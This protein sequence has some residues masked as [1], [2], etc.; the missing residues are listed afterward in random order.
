MVVLDICMYISV[1]V[2][3]VYVETFLL[4][5]HDMSKQR[6]FRDKGFKVM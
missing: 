5:G 6:R 3:Y 1:Y 4:A 2:S